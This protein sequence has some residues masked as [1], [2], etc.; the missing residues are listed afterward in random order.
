[1]I[2]TGSGAL[3]SGG[4]VVGLV[5]CI[6]ALGVGSATA[7]TCANEALRPSEASAT[8]LGLDAAGANLPD[9][10]AYEQASP[11]DKNW[12][13]VTATVPYAKASAAGGGVTFISK[14]GI[15][16]AEG[17]QE[18]PSYL[19]SRE[20]SDWL[21]GGLLPS[22]N[23]GQKARLLG[24]TPDFSSVFTLATRFGSPSETELLSRPGTGGPQS[25]V[26]DY[27]TGLQPEFV[28]TTKDGSLLFESP[29]KLLEGAAQGHPNTYFWDSASG[30]V[31]LAGALNDGSAP[32]QGAIA[33]PYD[34]VRGTNSATL[35]EGGGARDYYTENEHAIARDGSAAFF[36]AAG[37]GRLYERLNPSK[38]QSPVSAGKCANPVLA[39]TLEVSGS[40]K[41]DGKGPGGTELGG[42]RPAAFQ[43]ASADGKVAYFTSSEELTNEANTGSEPSEAL[44]SAAIARAKLGPSGA[45]EIN[46]SCVPARASGLAT[47]STYLYWAD[48][49]AGA[50]GRATLDC[51]PA[52]VE[53]S[54]ITGLAGIEDLAVG[55]G[56]I[57]WTEPSANR[58][59]AA[60]AD[61]KAASV[62][63]EFIT[64][65]LGPKGVAAG[66]GFV[67]WTN[68]AG[69]SLGRAKDDGSE[70][71]Q[72]F[73]EFKESGLKVPTQGVA[74]DAA[75]G[76]IYVA[77]KGVYI[78]SYGLDGSK[79]PVADIGVSELAGDADLA[80]DGSHVYWNYE[81]STESLIGRAKLDL[82]EKTRTFIEEGQG[83]EH[84]QSVAVAGEELYWANDPPL[85]S[86]PGNDLYRYEAATGGLEDISADPGSEN[87][88][89][90]Q[91]VVGAAE[92]GSV[93]YF[94]ANGDLDGAGGAEAGDCTGRLDTELG[95][96]CN[97]YRWKVG[98]T[99][100]SFLARL[101]VEG[102]TDVSDAA[103]W[104]ATP[105]R[106]TPESNFQKTAQASADGEAL[107]F[108]SQERLTAYDNRI[109]TIEKVGGEEVEG[110]EKVPELYLYQEGAG[111]ACVSCN[112][113][114]AAPVGKA[115]LGNVFPRTSLIPEPTASIASHNLTAEGQ[116]VF[117][118][119]PDALV[120]ADTNGQPG[121]PP[122]PGQFAFL[123]CLDVY[124]WEAA[125]TGGCT[126]AEASADGGCVY[127]LST[128]K[129]KEPSLFAD[130]S[131]S[132]EDAF[133]FTRARLVGQDKD[134][135]VDVYDVRGG[136]GIA[137]QSPPPPPPP[138]EGAEGCHGPA[139]SPPAETLPT[140]QSF[141][142]PGDPKPTHAK[143]HK[144]K[145]RAKKHKKH[146]R[147][148]AKRGA[149]R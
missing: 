76:H 20:G 42:P 85:A 60:D 8:N 47:D 21:S 121:C 39:C 32:A 115:G 2:K 44:P 25:K 145:P 68:A 136:G 50:I 94:V 123:T 104:A 12:G 30:K 103:N 133:F 74:V 22:A 6:C 65:A 97:L 78:Q 83:V 69:E 88:A 58:I 113:S 56:R 149:R 124:E 31:S 46:Q 106:V 146:H 73:I 19:A 48:R 4:V 101:G 53:A 120:G 59:G 98:E 84:P 131:L 128:G 114:G 16:G 45:E 96:E 139:S 119:T 117:F 9:C 35:S 72:D 77:L 99:Q 86:K 148:Q 143:K 41:S 80:L 140:T 1:M 87:G 127:L 51:K 122:Q 29:V 100:P 132:G 102:D 70:A 118:E 93:V 28:G 89:E 33:G 75:N 27:T 38:E 14:A 5:A 129:G 24:W 7:A 61:G 37:S 81:D 3:R 18:F 144:K 92:D 91:G 55:A 142:G 147:A 125:G 82:S 95:G 40:Q 137:A 71:N 43:A 116:R 126:E 90:V 79:D 26:V 134:D 23:E 11:V 13:D 107:L 15:P 10:R 110:I 54:F 108:R 66:G 111:I 63:R 62:N 64:G 57:Y 112:P 67:Y 130:A 141:S 135:L 138:C 36:T 34:W 52:G 105:T 49:I 109:V 17:A